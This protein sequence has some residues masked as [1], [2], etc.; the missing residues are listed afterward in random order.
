M[1]Q[2]TQI[3]IVLCFLTAC[4]KE[5]DWLNKKPDNALVV[6]TTL[7]DF[8]ALLSHEGKLNLLDVS[9]NFVSGE[10]YYLRENHWQLIPLGTQRNSYTWSNDL[11]FYQGAEVL[12]RSA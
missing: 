3:I 2:L 7:Q 1:K 6:P 8:K 12:I 5:T 9:L 4:Q 11:N 10:P